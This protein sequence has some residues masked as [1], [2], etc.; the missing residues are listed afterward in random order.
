MANPVAFVDKNTTFEIQVLA[1]GDGEA[2]FT[3]Y[4][5]DFQSFSYEKEEQNKV[6]IKRNQQGV[7]SFC[8]EGS[9]EEK[10]KINI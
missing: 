1:Y 2:D 9:A 6:M 4:E 7:I 8:R 3:L 5:D 10:L